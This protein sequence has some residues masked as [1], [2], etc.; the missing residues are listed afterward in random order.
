MKNEKNFE[1]NKIYNNT[2]E[3]ISLYES[4]FSEYA[5][6]IKNMFTANEEM[7]KYD[8]KDY[9]LIQAREEN[10]ILINQKIGKMQK[11]QNE[12]KSLCPRHPIVE[13]NIFESFSPK[14][15]NTSDIIREIEL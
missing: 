12:I 14:Q 5:R 8:P 9:D 7:L 2:G 1:N 4:E 15:E 13:V 10:L 6:Q 3:L 11:I